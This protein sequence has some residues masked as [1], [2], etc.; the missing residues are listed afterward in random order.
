MAKQW[1]RKWGGLAKMVIFAKS[2]NWVTLKSDIGFRL[3]CL[4]PSFDLFVKKFFE[5]GF[6][7]RSV[8]GEPAVSA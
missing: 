1:S 8:V 4:C 7:F 5:A 6:L 2:G 3:F